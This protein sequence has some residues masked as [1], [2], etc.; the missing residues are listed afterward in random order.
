MAKDLFDYHEELPSIVQITL[1]KYSFSDES[2]QTCERLLAEL[3]PLGY[4]FDY[5][6]DAI[7]FNLRKINLEL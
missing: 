5:G 1:F 7:P 6:L 4:T 3:N 2:Y